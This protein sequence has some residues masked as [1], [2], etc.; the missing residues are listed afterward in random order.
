MPKRRPKKQA[1]NGAAAAPKGGQKVDIG[2]NPFQ[3]KLKALGYWAWKTFDVG[4]MNQIKDLVVCLEKTQIRHYKT[5]EREAL[6]ATNSP[7]WLAAFSKYLNDVTE[8]TLPNE[9]YIKHNSGV[10]DWV[11]VID[12]LL[13]EAVMRVYKDKKAE[14]NQWQP[15]RREYN[16]AADSKFALTE[17]ESQAFFDAVQEIAT[18][19]KFPPNDSPV[20]NAQVIKQIVCIKFSTAAIQR[21]RDYLREKWE[22][23]VTDPAEKVTDPQSLI[24]TYDPQYWLGFRTGDTYVDAAA[25]IL[26]MQYLWDLK[27]TQERLNDIILYIQQ[28]TADPK[29]NAKLGKVGR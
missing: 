7:H 10:V 27:D 13:G 4:N 23:G 12:Y 16:F 3:R 26:R 22:T 14:Y 2:V 18:L 19:L 20:I 28:Y 6:K 8:G 21:Y 11:R 24:D 25:T 9:F 5:S 17:C 15:I 29:T 1:A